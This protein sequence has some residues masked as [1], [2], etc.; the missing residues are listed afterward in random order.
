M[1]LLM[2]IYLTKIHYKV[3]NIVGIAIIKIVLIVRHFLMIKVL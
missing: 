2:A 3:I 1:K